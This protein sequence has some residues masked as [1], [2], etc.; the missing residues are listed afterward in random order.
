[1]ADSKAVEKVEMMVE[2]TAARTVV[3][4]AAVTVVP[5]AVWW[6]EPMADSKAAEKVEKMVEK[7]VDE[8]VDY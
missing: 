6:A 3:M 1:M 4:M 5:L 8:M 7:M 2:K